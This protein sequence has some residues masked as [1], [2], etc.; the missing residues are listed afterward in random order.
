MTK[1]IITAKEKHKVIL[2]AFTII[3]SGYWFL[4]INWQAC[5]WSILIIELDPN[6][7]TLTISGIYLT[8]L[9]ISVFALVY[10]WIEWK[11]ERFRRSWIFLMISPVFIFISMILHFFHDIVLG[12]W[13]LPFS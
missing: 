3:A 6:I 5:V 12:G 10:A 1:N 2:L 8:L 9:I 7:T 4:V 11:L 13:V